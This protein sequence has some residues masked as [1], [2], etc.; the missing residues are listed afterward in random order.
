MFGALQAGRRL[1]N[2]TVG[3]QGSHRHVCTFPS[4]LMVLEQAP[5]HHVDMYPSATTAQ[6]TA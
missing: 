4:Y 3:F 6:R 2:F 1:R 5:H